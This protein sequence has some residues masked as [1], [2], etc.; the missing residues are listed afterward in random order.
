MRNAVVKNIDRN[1][2][3]IIKEICKEENIELKSY[4]DKWILRLSKNGINRHIIGYRFELNNSA[5]DAICSD[6]CATSDI[7][8]DNNIPCVKHSFF[9]SPS[10]IHHTNSDSNWI[11]M[12]KYLEEYKKIVCKPN[13]GTSGNNVISVSNE[14]ELEQAVDKI[15]IKSRSLAICPYY[16]IKNEYRVIILNGNV[17]VIYSKEKP[18]LIGNGKDTILQL[19]ANSNIEYKIGDF[20]KNINYYYVP[21]KDETFRLNWKHNLGLGS[22]A[23]I[24]HDNQL[25]KILSEIAAQTANVLNIKFASI[26][27]IETEDN[28]QVLEVNSGVMMECFSSNPENYEIAKSIYKE[29]IDLMF[30]QKN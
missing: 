19:L 16:D 11:V 25:T 7:L 30:N 3:S 5:T 6:K 28:Y 2:V 29:A 1:L 24:I 26:D 12:L 27:I 20:D 17:K 23:K 4:S 21:P 18:S 9:N 13:E 15:F 22:S 10:N 8:I 14:K